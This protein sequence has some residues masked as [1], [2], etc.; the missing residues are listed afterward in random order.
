MTDT[1]AS[2]LRH[3]A[4]AACLGLLVVTPAL[5]QG[6]GVQG[7]TT[8]IKPTPDEPA[9]IPRAD[10]H[11]STEGLSTDDTRF[12]WIAH[13][14]GDVDLVDYVFG[15]IRIG[16]DYEAILGDE[17]RPFD[18]NQGNYP[19]EGSASFRFEGFEISGVFHHESRH[20]SDR[21]KRFSVDWNTVGGRVM[22]HFTRG[23]TVVEVEAGFGG[24][25]HRTFVDYQWVG[26]AD[27]LVRQRLTPVFDVYGRGTGTLFGVDGSQPRGTQHGGRA[28]FGVRV[29]GRAGA[30][31]LFAGV[32]RMVDA[33]PLERVP[34]TWPFAGVRLV[35]R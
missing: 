26:D 20:L 27:V 15:R 11:L 32:E 29:N 22:R 30:V 2:C 5:A 16:G 6:P 17:L 7:A 18:P 35:S 21:P 3:A 34:M 19:L 1:F 9:F 13:F 10:F 12:K 4:A 33:Y 14:G 23:S 25:V 24:V 8:L 28:E 31:E